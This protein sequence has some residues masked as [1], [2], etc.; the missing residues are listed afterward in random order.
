M[1]GVTDL[2]WEVRS[3]KDLFLS[4]YFSDFYYDWE[5]RNGKAGRG[6]RLGQ[7]GFIKGERYQGIYRGM[8]RSR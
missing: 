3:S 4:Q 1:A 2:K 7:E 6:W 8:R 5:Q